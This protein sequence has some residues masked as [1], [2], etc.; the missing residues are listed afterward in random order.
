MSINPSLHFAGAQTARPLQ[1]ANEGLRSTF[2]NTVPTA[3]HEKMVQVRLQP[4]LPLILAIS[5]LTYHEGQQKKI[6]EDGNREATSSWQG[7][8]AES[9]LGYLLLKYTSGVYPLLGLGLAICRASK[10][11]NALDQLKAVITTAVTMGMGFIGANLLDPDVMEKMENNKIKALFET[12][13]QDGEKL[14]QWIKSLQ[15]HED[16]SV[17]SLG[18]HLGHLKKAM[19]EG[20][21]LNEKNEFK[22]VD[23]PKV[24]REAIGALKGKVAEYIEPASQ[25]ALNKAGDVQHLAQKLL[26]HIGED[27]SMVTKV[28]RSVNPICCFMFSAFLLGTPIANWINSRLG[29]RHPELK[30]KEMKQVLFPDSQRI[31]KRPEEKGHE[32]VHS[33]QVNPGPYI[34][35]PDVAGGRPMQ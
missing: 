1:A 29:Q 17:K 4:L 12:E 33:Y 18:K 26:T 6:A 21:L 25:D 10:E 5:A 22:Q 13:G 23:S 19:V 20:K 16:K 24:L 8:V 34:S 31:L 32:K 35:C 28:T 11:N 3:A 15:S 14:S 2:R 30:K 9:T 7:V 27:Q